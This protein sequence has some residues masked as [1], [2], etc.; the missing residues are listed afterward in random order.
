MNKRIKEL[1][2]SLGLTLEK[3]GE[4]IGVKKAA[5]SRWE[6][7]DKIADRM[8]L[9]ICREFNVNEEWLRNG[10]GEMFILSDN[11]ATALISRLLEKPDNEFYN[12]ILNILHTY[13]H[14]SPELQEKLNIFCKQ[15]ITAI[16]TQKE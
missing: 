4:R 14:L 12:M 9:A 7:G 10:T 2:K 11:E 1:R 6:N 5:V 8:V 3:F 16:K 13:E 15:L